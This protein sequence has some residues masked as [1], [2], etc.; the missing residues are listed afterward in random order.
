MSRLRSKVI[1]EKCLELSKNQSST[2]HCD[3]ASAQMCE[4]LTK[5]KTIIM[6]QPL[7]SP[8]L[9]PA[10]VFLFRTPIKGK[11]FAGIEEINEKA[12]QKRAIGDTNWRRRARSRGAWKDVLRQAEIR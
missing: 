7:F 12:K 9:A 1:R 6:P 3:K 8:A 2:L 5:S 11:H 10:D 4:F